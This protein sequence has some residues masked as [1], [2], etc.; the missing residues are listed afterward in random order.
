VVNED[1]GRAPHGRG[2]P[3]RQDTDEDEEPP[4]T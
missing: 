4:G 1:S 2:R 3:E